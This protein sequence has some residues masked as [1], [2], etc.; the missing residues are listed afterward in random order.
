VTACHYCRRI[1]PAAHLRP[2]GPAGESICH[3]CG[4]DPA[5]AETTKARMAAALEAAEAASSTGAAILKPSGF[6]EAKFYG[7]PPPV[8]AAARMAV[9]KFTAGLANQVASPENLAAWSAIMTRIAHD[10]IV[11]AFG[12]VDL[13]VAREVDSEGHG[14]EVFTWGPGNAI[15]VGDRVGGS[16]L[17]WYYGGASPN[18]GPHPDGC[19]TTDPNAQRNC[20]SDGHHECATCACYDEAGRVAHGDPPIGGAR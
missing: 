3:P 2:Y 12:P 13:T 4:S 10:V 5:R 9:R 16:P 1:L 19:H 14:C 6:E 15:P 18:P 7:P 8:I 20:H 17:T 11:P